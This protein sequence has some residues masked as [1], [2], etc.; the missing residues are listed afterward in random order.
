MATILLTGGT[1]MI[2]T[3]LQR[4]L[5]G[6]GYLVIVLVRDNAAY[7][8]A[9]NITCA[10]WNVEKGEVDKEAIAAAD[11]IIHLAGAN[12]GEKRWTK[13]RKR[14]IVESRVKSG[15]LIVKS[16]GEIPNKIKAVISVSAIGWYGPDTAASKRN[17]FTENAPADNDFLGNTCRLWEESIKPVEASGKRLIITRLGI[18][19][20][21]EGGALAEFKKPLKAG[22][23]AILGNGKQMI[24]WIHIDDLC[25]LFLFAIEQESMRGIYNAVADETI[26]N[27]IFT[28]TLAGKLRGRLFIPVYVPAFALK[29]MMGEMSIEVLKSTTVSNKKIHDA[30][31]TFL[32]PSVEAALE[33]LTTGRLSEI[34]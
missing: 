19:W 32:Y 33:N 10:K 17:G 21:K 8:K 23:A 6:K 29:L 13:N 28:L 34:Y 7:L 26:S 16:L 3:A 4:F 2:G 12:V 18:V 27:K 15:E 11:Y 5:T 30:G 20:S 24:S 22:M 9:N 14:E 1:G 25:R 31:F